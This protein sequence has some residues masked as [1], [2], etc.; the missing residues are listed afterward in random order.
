MLFMTSLI[1][2]YIIKHNNIIVVIYSMYLNWSNDYHI[3]GF[4]I[5]P[6]LNLV[7]NS[8]RILNSNKISLYFRLIHFK[9]C[10]TVSS[11]KYFCD[12][13]MAQSRAETCRQFKIIT[14][15]KLSCVLTPKKP[16]LI[17]SSGNGMGG[18][19]LNGRL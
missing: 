18:Y 12:L 2:G 19:G 9:T 17:G 8:I 11:N 16:L 5:Y 14:S 13:K 15:S 10:C 7:M 4:M 3:V 1:S 6:D